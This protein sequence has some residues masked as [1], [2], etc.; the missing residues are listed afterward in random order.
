MGTVVSVSDPHIGVLRLAGGSSVTAEVAMSDSAV[1]IGSGDIDLGDWPIERCAC[2]RRSVTEYELELDGETAA[3]LPD[4]PEAFGAEVARR[5]KHIR[6]ADRVEAVRREPGSRE[7]KHRRAAT[8]RRSL[9][10]VGFGVLAALVGG[11]VIATSVLIVSGNTRTTVPVSTTTTATTAPVFATVFDLTPPAL[12]EAWN[13]TAARLN[14]AL[15]VRGRLGPGSFESV[16]APTL[17]LQGTVDQA[18]TLSRVVLAGD[19]SGDTASDEAIIA[20]WGV[21]IAVAEPELAAEGRRNILTALGFDLATRDLSNLDGEIERSGIRYSLRYL[22][23]F[24]SVLF[25]IAEM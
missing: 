17:T 3:F 21:A 23:E 8:P 16:L 6:L 2:R 22:P 10:T 1:S 18:G 24:S 4:D 19:P 7:P 13:L 15:P 11:L 25:T 20:A 12:A 9:R 14:V 5:F